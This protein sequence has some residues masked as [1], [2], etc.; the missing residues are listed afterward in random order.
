MKAVQITAFGP[1]SV[2]VYQEVE[3][4][5]INHDQILVQVHAAGIN[6]ID[7]K[8][9]KGLGFI[10]QKIKDHLPWTPGY[11]LAGTVEQCGD[12]ISQFKPGD[13]VYGMIALNRAGAYA[14]YAIVYPNEIAIKP[15][16]ISWSEAAG[17][18]LA[19]LT[20]WQ[21]LHNTGHL[22]SGQNVL[23]HAAAGGVGHLAVQFAK[24]QNAHV[25]A[26]A[27]ANHHELLYSLGVDRCIDYIKE[28]FTE[29]AKEMDLII[30]AVGGETGFRSLECLAPNGL[31]VCLP[32]ISTQAVTIKAKEL[33]RKAVGMVVTPNAKDLH[34]FRSLFEDKRINI[35]R[36]KE[37]T[38]QNANN[39]HTLL[40]TGHV[41]GKLVLINS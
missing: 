37:F 4:P 12:S 8:T 27:S 15:S 26:T 21:A 17:V 14:D 19:G 11:D 10:A 9:R 41:A 2:L 23:I 31:L 7:W 3:K 16:T 30:D 33:G 28:D 29:I 25:T 13:E 36:E 34:I 24:A 38:L 35:H 39:A 22:Q 32:T 1:P 20:A 40:E 5:Q 6:P 18:P